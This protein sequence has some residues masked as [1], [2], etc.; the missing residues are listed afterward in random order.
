MRAF[1]NIVHNFVTYACVIKSI[2]ELETRSI[3]LNI[4]NF[5][6][7]ILRLSR[8]VIYY[9][10]SIEHKHIQLDFA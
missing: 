7:A 8:S 1:Y 3:F 6:I 10:I 5:K 9:A 4:L 2:S